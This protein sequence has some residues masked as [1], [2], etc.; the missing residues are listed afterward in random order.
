V[1][2]CARQLPCRRWQLRIARG[3]EASAHE[4][5]FKLE[6][7]MLQRCCHPNIVETFEA[8]YSRCWQWPSSQLAHIGASLLVSAR[9][10]KS[11]VAQLKSEVQTHAGRVH[12]RN[13]W[14]SCRDEGSMYMIL[15]EAQHGDLQNLFKQRR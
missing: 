6:A 14:L 11:S 3:Q 1:P 8:W 10:P 13:E 9:V 7:R 4:D 15:E 5:A 2:S 12:P